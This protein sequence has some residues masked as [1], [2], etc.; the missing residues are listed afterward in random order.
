MKLYKK[1]YCL[2]DIRK[3]LKAGAGNQVQTGDL[4]LGKVLLT[5]YFFKLLSQHKLT[6]NKLNFYEK[7]VL[8][9]YLE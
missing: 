6:A 3:R 5:R 9:L 1:S 7:K 4:N 2:F 8:R